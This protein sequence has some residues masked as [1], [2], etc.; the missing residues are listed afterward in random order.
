MITNLIDSEKFY[1]KKGNGMSGNQFLYIVIIIALGYLL[2]RLNIIKEKDGEALSRIIFNFTLPSLIIYSFYGFEMDI[3]LVYLI[4]IAFIY[5]LFL[6][7][8]GFLT[9]KNE[10]RKIK[11][12]MAMM[13]PGFNIGLFAYPLVEAIWGQKGLIHFVMFDIGNAFIVFGL[14]YLIASFYASEE[15]KLNYKDAFKRMSK[16]I[17]LLTYIIVCIINLIGLPLP[18]IVVEVTEIVSKANM[19]LSLLLLGIYLSFSFEKNYLKRIAKYLALRYLVGL[20]VGILLFFILPFEDMFKYTILIGFI[21]PMSVSALAYSVQFGYD[22]KFTGT[23][24]NI[25]IFISFVL[26]WGI[27]T[28]L[29]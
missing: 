18:N 6:G 4:L 14:A 7:F 13:V 28:L 2:K 17:P 27:E 11:G 26:V 19:P 10:S 22:Q 15:E 8:L 20:S 12:M 16:S 25:T 21:L 9:F 24:S 3:S 1:W 29:L 5:G 23:V